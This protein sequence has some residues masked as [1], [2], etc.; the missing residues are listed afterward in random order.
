MGRIG[1]IK[2]RKNKQD[3]KKA[4]V[5]TKLNR[6]ITVAI[7]EG[8]EDPEYNASL[9]TALDKARASNM[10]NDNIQ[11]AIKKAS[12]EI[13]NQTFEKIM[14]EGYGPSGVAVIL[15]VL[16]ENRNR[17]VGEIRYIFDKNGGNLGT[18]GCVSYLFERIGQIL[19]EKSELIEEEMLLADSL[20]VGADDLEADEE[21]YEVKVTPSMFLEVKDALLKKGYSILDS[22]I[23]YKPTNL[24]HLSETDSIRMEKLIDMLEDNHDVQEIHH[25]WSKQ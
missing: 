9:K 4:S 22:D 25:N 19:I 23:I 14:Y 13:G 20:E 15:E 11:R 1:N 16:T 3:S 21:V 24:I 10:P 8:G 18:S 6:L 2:E 17:T 5:Y 12:G 7:R